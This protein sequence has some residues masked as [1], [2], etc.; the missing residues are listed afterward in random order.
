MIFGWRMLVWSC[1]AAHQSCL[2]DMKGFDESGQWC[3]LHLLS[4]PWNLATTFLCTKFWLT[5][6]IYFWLKVVSHE[7][8]TNTF[9][10]ILWGLG[11]KAG[12]RLYELQKHCSVFQPVDVY[13]Q[14]PESWWGAGFH[15]M[16]FQKEDAFPIFLC[17]YLQA[18]LSCNTDQ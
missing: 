1:L 2:L 16:S 6:Q 9:A 14:W 7:A 17:S 15:H 5:F 3:N 18:I 11:P 10:P 8:T 4:W 12:C 13:V